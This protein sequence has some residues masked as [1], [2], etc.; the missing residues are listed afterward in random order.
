METIFKRQVVTRQNI[1]DALQEFSEQYPD[2][3]TFDDWLRKETYKYAV[4]Y[5]EKKYPPKHILST[6]TGI[7]TTKFGGGEE[8]NRVFRQLGFEVGDK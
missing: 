7:P 1:L 5:G 8:T 3:E 4:R 6:A 2:P